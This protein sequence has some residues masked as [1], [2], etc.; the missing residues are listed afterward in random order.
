M[1][2]VAFLWLWAGCSTATTVF[3]RPGGGNPA[4]CGLDQAAFCETFD[5]P[6][7]GGR[8]GDLDERAW[9]FARWAHAVQYDWLRLPAST[10]NDHV[11]PAS[12]CGMPFSGILPPADVRICDGPSKTGVPSFQLN[13]VFDDQAAFALHSMRIRQPFDFAGRVG[14]VVW[15]VDAKVN[16]FNTGHGW[17]FEVWI[18]A[19]PAPLPHDHLDG[20]TSLPRNGVGFVFE[21]G[22]DC[23]EDAAAW[24]NALENVKVTHDDQLFH[25]YPFYQIGQTDRRCFRVAD[26]RLNHFELRID[27]T[28]AELWAS[29]FDDP[30][31]LILRASVENLDLSF[32]R[33]YVH[34]E[35]GGLNA[36]E[37]GNVTSSQTFRWDNLGFDGPT[38]PLPRSYDVPDNT[39]MLSGGVQLGWY[40]HDGLPHLFTVHGV[41]LSG[42]LSA[43]FNFALQAGPGTALTYRL[44]GNAPHSFVY[45]DTGVPGGTHGFSVTA[46]LSELLPGDNTVEVQVPTTATV[47]SIGA[48]DLTVE[49]AR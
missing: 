33:G 10:M 32:E 37:D 12:F 18:T 11:F 42:A 22:A 36:A 27:K 43:S 40:I 16:P 3:E 17:W 20:V 21:N 19:D 24:N 6:A 46:P 47:E 15:D 8:G 29:D 48:L 13:E 25:D 38:L 26:A 4:S 14:K 30:S 44:N 28:R 41:E 9:S 34:F 49:V 35:H 2:A 45:P 23:P 7:P 39:E 31:N 5:T 1:R